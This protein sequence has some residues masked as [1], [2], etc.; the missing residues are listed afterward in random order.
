MASRLGYASSSGHG[1]RG[2]GTNIAGGTINGGRPLATL[3][4]IK[5]IAQGLTM[6]WLFAL[7][8]GR[9]DSDSYSSADTLGYRSCQAAS[10]TVG[11][12]TVLSAEWL[13]YRRQP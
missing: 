4:F 2:R 6:A 5:L 3:L 12:H 11:R 13:T 9:C 1:C 8:C 10:K 7:T